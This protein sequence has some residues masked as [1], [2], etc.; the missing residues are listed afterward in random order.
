MNELKSNIYTT[1]KRLVCD[2]THEKSYLI[3]Y[4]KLKFYVWQGIIVDK[5]QEIIS[6]DPSKWLEKYK[7][8]NTQNGNAA[9]KDFEKDF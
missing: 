3:D 2:W 7:T 9:A 8:F 4:R 1:H 5:V 6:F